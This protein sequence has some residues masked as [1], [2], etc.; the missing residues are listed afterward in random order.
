M[1]PFPHTSELPSESESRLALAYRYTRNGSGGLFEFVSE[2]YTYTF[3]FN[4]YSP[5]NGHGKIFTY[6]PHGD[7][8]FLYPISSIITSIDAANT[9]KPES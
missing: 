1:N 6:E 9:S 7:P 4:P 3:V 2:G 5:P 8:D